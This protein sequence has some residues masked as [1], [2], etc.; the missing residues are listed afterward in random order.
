MRGT[1]V[2]AELREVNGEPIDDAVG[3]E[4]TPTRGTDH[5]AGW[6]VVA[7]VEVYNLD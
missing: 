7:Y 3:T 2:E 4:M 1:A 5:R 6:V